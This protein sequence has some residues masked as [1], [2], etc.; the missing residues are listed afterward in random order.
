MLTKPTGQSCPYCED[1]VLGEDE[2]TG[3]RICDSCHVAFRPATSASRAQKQRQRREQ[4]HTHW[5]EQ[6]DDTDGRTRCAGGFERA[7]YSW[8]NGD[9]YAIDAYG[10]HNDGLLVPHK[11]D[12]RL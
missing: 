10:E 4:R 11:R 6:I 7:Y 2:R 8:V 9:E 3:A 5:R 12:W 1:G